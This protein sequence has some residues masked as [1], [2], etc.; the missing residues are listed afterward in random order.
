VSG[1]GE[2]GAQLVVWGHRAEVISWQLKEKV[3]VRL[4]FAGGL[5]W[6]FLCTGRFRNLT[7]WFKEATDYWF[8]N[9]SSLQQRDLPSQA[10]LPFLWRAK[11]SCVIR[12]NTGIWQ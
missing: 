11:M 7:C 5:R 2:R 4:K 6:C 10:H 8:Y 9:R 3:L 12:T 1:D